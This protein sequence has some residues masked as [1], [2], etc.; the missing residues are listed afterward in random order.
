MDILNQYIQ[1]Q[2]HCC[3]SNAKFQSMTYVH[4]FYELHQVLTSWFFLK[5]FILYNALLDGKETI[6]CTHVYD[7]GFHFTMYVF[8]SKDTPRMGIINPCVQ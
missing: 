6:K 1:I 8:A 2:V 7:I 4:N 3:L 5:S